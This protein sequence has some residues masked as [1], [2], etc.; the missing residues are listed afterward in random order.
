MAANLRIDLSPNIVCDERLAGLAG[1]NPGHLLVLTGSDT[2]IHR[3]AG[4]ATGS[5][6]VALTAPERGKGVNDGYAAN[7][8]VRIGFPAAG[9]KIQAVLADGETIGISDLLYPA[10]GGEVSATVALG[11][12]VLQAEE[13]VTTS[14]STALI[15]CRVTG[16]GSV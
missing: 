15:A 11:A 13:A 16:L 6:I 8:T 1:I 7:E 5:L 2:V 4:A 12:P 9:Q 14:G 3:P 10:A